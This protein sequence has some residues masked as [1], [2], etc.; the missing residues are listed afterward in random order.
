MTLRDITG[1]ADTNVASVSYHFGSLGALCCATTKHA[2]TRLLDEQM[3]RLQALDED[4]TVEEIARA[5]AQPIIGALSDPQSP[6]RALLRI[7]DRA[8]GGPP[9]EMR[10][11]SAGR[12][13]ARRR[14]A[15]RAPAPGAPGR[16]RRGAALPL[17]VRVRHPARAR[18]R[19]PPRADHDGKCAAD[20]ERLLVP[21]I[22]GD[23][24]RRRRPRVETSTRRAWTRAV[25]AGAESPAQE[26]TRFHGGNMRGLRGRLLVGAIALASLATGGTAHAQGI[27]LVDG[28]TAPVFDYDQAIRER[29]YIPNGQDAD[30]DGVEDRTAIEIMRPKTRREGPGDRR[31]EPVLHDAPAGSS[32]ASASPTSTATGSTTAGRSGTTTTSSRA[33]TR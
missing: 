10:T 22:A 1:A 23:A 13:R 3:P 30:L 12:A 17:G 18:R 2:I 24:L 6:D 27:Q 31:A 4:A 15:D 20:L 9:G 7:F 16:R 14:R 32:S 8:L 29:V 19:A 28:K 33:G 25:R 21:V 26:E 11:G 5:V